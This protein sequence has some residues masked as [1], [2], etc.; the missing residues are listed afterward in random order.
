MSAT[1]SDSARFVSLKKKFKQTQSKPGSV[2]LQLLRISLN[3]PNGS[4]L[5]ASDRSSFTQGRKWGRRKD[6]KKKKKKEAYV[7]KITTGQ[8][9]SGTL[10][11]IEKSLTV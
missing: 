9:F 7:S 2:C 1:L 8:I 5:S 10:A 11:F 6:R 4:R 3:F